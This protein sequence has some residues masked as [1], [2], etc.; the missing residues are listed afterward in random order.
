MLAV[1]RGKLVALSTSFEKRGWFHD[2][3]TGAGERERIEIKATQRSRIGPQF[4]AK[5]TDARRTVPQAGIPQT[6][7]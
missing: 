6:M 5:E 7:S 2:E 4:L 3:L 1:S